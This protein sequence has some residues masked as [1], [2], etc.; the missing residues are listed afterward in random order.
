VTRPPEDAVVRAARRESKLALGMWLVAMI[1]SITFCYLN[2]YERPVDTLSF[3]LWFPDWV[4]W[5]II[6]PWLVCTLVSIVFAF[7]IMGN[8]PL[9]DEIVDDRQALDEGGHA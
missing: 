7:G 4:F 8:E 5:G 2:G 6:A 9:G 1:Y 3:V